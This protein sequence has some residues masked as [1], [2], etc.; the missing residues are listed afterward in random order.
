MTD[1]APRLDISLFAIHPRDALPLAQEAEKA[2]FYSA[3]VGD[4]FNDSF[5]SLSGVAAVTERIRL[6]TNIATWTRTPVSMARACRSIDRLSEGR[7]VLGLGSMPRVWN[8]NYHGIP[9]QAPLSRMREYVE[10]IRKLWDATPD[11]PVDHEGRFYR[12]S[13]FRPPDPPPRPR[14]PIF[15]GATRRKMIV[16][17]GAWADGILLNWDYT[18]PWLKEHGLPA[19]EE[20]AKSAGRSLSDLDM[21]GGRRVFI[22]EDPGDAERARQAFR[23]NTASTYFRVDYHKQLLAE[24]GFGEEVE[25][26]SKAL[27]AG[28]VEGA[29]RAV[30]DRMVDAFT[31]IGT[32]DHCRQRVAEYTSELNWF[33]IATPTEGMDRED[34]VKAVRKV[35]QTF[36]DG[37]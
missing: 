11:T 19:L 17:T 14:L 37:G 24:I 5:V 9:G 16:E 15:I 23:V 18:I 34:R 27:D 2:G 35:I 32:A 26:G 10:L 7:F 36:G 4:A 33:S 3:T 12:V 31:F 20:G 22:T 1:Q 6:V 30:S 29:A 8:E 28:D 25:A 13:G 21:M